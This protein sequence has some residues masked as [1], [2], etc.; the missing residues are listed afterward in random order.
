MICFS[1][2]H[3][4]VKGIVSS[5][6][7]PPTVTITGPLVAPLGTVTTMLVLFQLLAAAGTPLKVTVLVPWVAA[8]PVPVIVTELPTAPDPA[9]IDEMCGTVPIVK[10]M[11]LLVCPPT[12][13]NTGPLRTE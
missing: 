6:A 11:P 9:D 12:V 7:I 3:N 4:T 8:K 2:L 13:T 10:T 5:L 1:R